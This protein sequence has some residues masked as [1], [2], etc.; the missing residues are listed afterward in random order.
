MKTKTLNIAV[1]ENDGQVL[2]RKKPAGSPPYDE[3]WYLFGGEVTD[4]ISP[5]EATKSIVKTQAGVDIK[6]RENIGWDTEI[7]NDL[8]DERKQFIYL[9]SIYDYVGGD[10]ASGEGIER[11]EWVPIEKLNDYDIVPPSRI[12]FEK[13]GYIK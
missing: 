10:L 2:M 13:I 4:G 1:I 11:V 12:L 3:T 6:L 8:D 9:D 5:E 7:K